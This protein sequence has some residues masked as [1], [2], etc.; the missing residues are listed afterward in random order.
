MNRSPI[1]PKFEPQD[2]CG[3]NE[4]D[5]HTDFA[6]FLSEARKH[7]GQD[8]LG[9]TPPPPHL[10]ESAERKPRNPSWKRSLF[11]WLKRDKRNKNSKE[12]AKNSHG[13]TRPRGDC[14]S[15]L[16]RGSGDGAR[17]WKPLSGPITSHFNGI[18]QEEDE[19]P[20]MCLQKMNTS[21]DVQSYGPVYLVT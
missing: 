1:Y 18:N 17:P 5:P 2:Y 14:V 11:S 6:Q 3:G 20:Y 19:V 12:A 13:A 7:A 15:G 16:V 9:A 21:K 8:I 4:F 10:E